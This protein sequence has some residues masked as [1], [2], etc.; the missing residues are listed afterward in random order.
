MPRK[1]APDRPPVNPREPLAATTSSLSPSASQGSAKRPKATKAKQSPARDANVTEE[2]AGLTIGELYDKNMDTLKA[3]RDAEAAKL[4]DKEQQISAEYGVYVSQI[5]LSTESNGVI[6]SYLNLKCSSQL[7]VL[8]EHLRA[9][10]EELDGLA[11]V[12]PY[13][14]CD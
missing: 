2:T 1:E 12:G 7:S 6:A 10:L 11:K 5:K 8:G 13:P 14:D 3:N 4:G 9:A